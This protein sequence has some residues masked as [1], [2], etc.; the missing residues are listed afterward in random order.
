M[1]FHKLFAGGI[2]SSNLFES[3]SVLGTCSVFSLATCIACMPDGRAV[4]TRLLRTEDIRQN[5]ALNTVATGLGFI[6]WIVA[7]LMPSRKTT[8]VTLPMPLPPG[9]R[10]WSNKQ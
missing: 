9:T 4:R 5:H 10:N 8:E 1:A 2:A 6:L 7:W 3:L